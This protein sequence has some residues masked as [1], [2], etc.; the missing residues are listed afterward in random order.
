MALG[1]GCRAILAAGRQWRSNVG[2]AACGVW[3]HCL[4]RRLC[5]VMDGAYRR[6]APA[7]RAPQ[8]ADSHRRADWIG[9]DRLAGWPCR[10]E[11]Q[12]A[13]N[14]YAGCGD[15][16]PGGFDVGDRLALQPQCTTAFVAA[17]GHGYGDA[18]RR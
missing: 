5:P 12:P 10:I 16:A 14:G 13:T 1:G 11:W 15:A 6:A 17:A 8:L 7:W 9:G 3:R 4:D 18:G 2:R